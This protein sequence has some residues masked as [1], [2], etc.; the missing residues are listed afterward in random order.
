MHTKIKYF[1]HLILKALCERT[2][3]ETPAKTVTKKRDIKRSTLT[4][5]RIPIEK[6]PLSPL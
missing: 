5:Y 6:L 1:L 2:Q 3:T 4:V